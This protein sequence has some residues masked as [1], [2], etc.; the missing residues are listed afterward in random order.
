MYPCF[1][2]LSTLTKVAFSL[3]G[4]FVLRSIHLGGLF[5]LSVDYLGIAAWY[6]WLFRQSTLGRAKLRCILCY[7]SLVAILLL[8]LAILGMLG[9]S[10]VLALEVIT[11]IPILPATL[12]LSRSSWSLS[13]Y[14]LCS[15]RSEPLKKKKI[16][17]CLQIIRANLT[18]WA[19]WLRQ[20]LSQNYIVSR[21]NS[22]K[23]AKETRRL[24]KS[25]LLIS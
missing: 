17:G 9:H 12:T 3:V 4:T 18:S 14:L 6:W 11:S 8:V 24:F 22:E 10:W 1:A 20:A 21:L 15:S 25:S 19:G 7:I 23:F 5:I 2:A 16:F 13:W